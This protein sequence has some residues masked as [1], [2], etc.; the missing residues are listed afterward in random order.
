MACPP[1]NVTRHEDGADQAPPA[2]DSG[3]G[4]NRSPPPRAGMG[5]AIR[6]P[7]TDASSTSTQS[8]KVEAFHDVRGLDGWDPQL[9]GHFPLRRA[10]DRCAG[11]RADRRAAGG[12]PPSPVCPLKHAPRVFFIG[13]PFQ[14]KT[15]PSETSRTAKKQERKN[16]P[17]ML[18][19]QKH[20]PAIKKQ[21]SNLCAKNLLD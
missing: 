2:A 12:R 16:Q 6:L 21:K 11:R 8:T 10:F 7:P 9:R 4:P 5:R 15:R 13:T 3:L 14:K 18:L 19:L 1:L 20:W 17:K